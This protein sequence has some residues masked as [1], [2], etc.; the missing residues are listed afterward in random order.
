MKE[1]YNSNM[2]DFLFL[3]GY[4]IDKGRVE[5]SIIKKQ[6]EEQSRKYK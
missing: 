5:A 3:V 2:R 1:V 4:K 6:Q